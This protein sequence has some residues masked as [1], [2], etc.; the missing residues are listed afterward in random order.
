MDKPD[1][2]FEVVTGSDGPSLYAN[3]YRIAGPKPWGGGKIVY[4]FKVSHQELA[5]LLDEVETARKAV[6]K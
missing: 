2:R 4:R 5:R 3:S 1:I 6:Q